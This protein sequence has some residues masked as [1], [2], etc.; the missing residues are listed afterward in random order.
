MTYIKSLE[1]HG[2]KSFA[3][4]T[5]LVFPKG[6]NIIVGS[7]GSGKCLKGDSKVLLA[8]GEFKTIKSL[9][10]NALNKSKHVS[11]LDDGVLTLENP[12]NIKVLCLN[13]NT[14][15]ISEKRVS[16]FVKRA[17][18][19][20]LVKIKTRS[21]RCVVAT[22]HHPVFV[23]KNKKIVSLNAGEIKTGDYIAM[24]KKYDIQTSQKIDLLKISPDD[25]LYVAWSQEYKD[26]IIKARKK[27][28][29]TA[30]GIPKNFIKGAI[31]GQSLNLGWL[32]KIFALIGEKNKIKNV[33]E[34]RAMHGNSIK[35]PK[36]LSL[37]LAR[38][39]AYLIAEG[40]IRN[41]TLR[42]VNNCK[43][44]ID[45]FCY[46]ANKVFG[47]S[48]TVKN[49]KGY[50]YDALIFNRALCT[51]LEKVLGLKIHSKA[52]TKIIPFCILKAPKKIIASFLGA[53]Y[54]C[55]GWIAKDR[56]CLEYST[57]SKEIADGILY[58]MQR[59]GIYARIKSKDIS[60]KHYYY[61]RIYGAESI[62]KLRS[63]GLRFLRKD[64]ENRLLRICNLK[65]NSWTSYD[66]LPREINAVVRSLAK[67][68]GINVKNFSKKYPRLSAYYNNDCQPTRKGIFLLIPIFEQQY[69]YVLRKALNLCL[70]QECLIQTIDALPMSRQHASSAIG[71]NKYTITNSWVHG[72]FNAK[73]KNLLKLYTYLKEELDD[74]LGKASADLKLLKA[75]VNS[76]IYW[77]QIVS[78]QEVNA[79]EWVYDLSI[80]KHHNFISEGFFVHN[81]NVIDAL[82]FVLGK[83]SKKSMRAEKLNDLIFNGG[84]KGKPAKSCSVTI[85]F[86]NSNKEF[87]YEGD[88][89]SITRIV[90]RDGKS[91][92]KINDAIVK[93]QEILN[94]LAFANLNPDGYN[95]ILQG[96]IQKFV[97][98]S[99]E[100]R[101]SIIEEISGISIYENKKHKAML[102][103]GKVEEKL[104][105]ARAVLSERE[106]FL[107]ELIN[108][109]K[110][111]EQYLK[112]KQELKELKA[113]LLFK[114]I[115]LQET[116]KQELEEKLN[117]SNKAISEYE[118]RI[119][120]LKALML[121]K[122]DE[123]ARIKS[124]IEKRGQEEQ[125]RLSRE[126]EALKEK[127]L[128][129]QNK[130]ESHEAELKRIKERKTSVKN[131]LSDINERINKQEMRLG[132]DYLK[133]K[134][135][136]QA[137]EDELLEKKDKLLLLKQ[138][139]E[140]MKEYNKLLDK[141][142]RAEGN[143]KQIVEKISK[144]AGEHSAIKSKTA[145][146]EE[147][148]DNLNAR[149]LK[150]EAKRQAGIN[151]LKRGV[152]EVLKIK[153][154]V[155][156]IHGTL[157]ELG[158]VDK[159]YATALSVCAGNK[160]FSIVT[161]TDV[162]AEQCINYL[163][164]N[165]LGIA[166]FMPLNKIRG[167]KISESL[168]ELKR[169]SG[170]IDFA[171]NL[172][173]FD[174]KYRPA[175]ELALGNTLVVHD[176]E[177]A[178][179]V[180]I[181]IVRMVTLSGDLIESSGVITGGYRNPNTA[182]FIEQGIEDNLK[183][184][185]AK[186][187]KYERYLKELEAK[188]A[189]LN[190]E[191]MS[192][193]ENRARQESI[194]EEL[195]NTIQELGPKVKPSVDYDLL[196]N[197]IKTLE[198][199][200]DELKSKTEHKLDEKQLL[201]IKESIDK[202][203][204]QVSDLLVEKRTIES[205]LN[206]LLLKEAS[207]LKSILADLDKEKKEFSQEL[208]DLK[209][210]L[211]QTLSEL[212]QKEIEE[213]KFYGKLK[214]FYTERDKIERLISKLE[215]DESAFKDKIY[216]LKEKTQEDRIKLASVVAKLEGLH[217]AF[218]E[219]K[220]VQVKLLKRPV[221]EI[222]ASIRKLEVKIESFGNVNLKALEA[223]KEAKADYDKIK[224]KS[225]KLNY[226]KQE[227]LNVIETIE[228]RKKDAFLKTF[229]EVSKNFAEIFSA[230]SPGGIAKM[231]LDN[232]E[233]PFEGGV[234]IMA[235]PKGKKILNLAS[236]SG[237]EKTITALAFIFSIQEYEPAPF[238][239]MDEVDAALDKY[240]SEVLAEL[241]RNY[242][243][244]AQF[245]VIS[246]ND[247]MISSADYLYGVSMNPD[248]LSKVVTLKLP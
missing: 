206:N 177:A 222:D 111:A 84:K 208:V 76:D 68:L 117:A 78:I 226:E 232:P 192:L 134:K 233:N 48:C 61:I 135:E 55:D 82:C 47:V 89:F 40:T 71:L 25:K 102:E 116:K 138:A 144:L 165:Q 231:Y 133:S 200:R 168:K 74:L 163:R 148:L 241:L 101:R 171:I 33:K 174:E 170:V 224:E 157:S 128:M 207:K 244:N 52:S 219:F 16:A 202:L 199:K 103:L 229:N 201:G 85:V 150:L 166:S 179:N 54:D 172:V 218:K 56:S 53:L 67:K 98:L 80:E 239:I 99:P 123:L 196:L 143:L 43:E 246:H 83:I 73:H 91:I 186:K 221:Q 57:A 181:G 79:E 96:D 19:K 152:R 88:E 234:E 49:Y 159:R 156:G 109:K 35:I 8:N 30:L 189:E 45:D 72:K 154:R 34:I 173:N 7:N 62:K 69:K 81:S 23:F 32:V 193:R 220:D 223:Y 60:N 64:K 228:S 137:I 236:M 86:D 44:I 243:K 125:N 209:S 95:I 194:I 37:E 210:S 115:H 190:E 139:R 39:L 66:V 124:E 11:K 129:I 247:D 146:V 245:I 15:K 65:T 120:D 188:A 230:L 204:T 183:E 12:E 215:K 14:L 90:R 5:R 2:F 59:F 175:F 235:R 227:I 46:C 42:I 118:K 63:Y 136:L 164:R 92:Y 1:L 160:L 70:N 151:Y 13:T 203:N 225:D 176:M 108:E 242:S 155:P 97:S 161:D 113:N 238:Y 237:G 149:I 110:Q 216:K 58:L 107:K 31:D 132:D 41:G 182:S 162:V 10:E 211:K 212:K 24:P 21:G 147:F 119:E 126:I 114:K 213:S 122:K 217:T 187:Q 26:L 191:I 105:E 214:K 180:G 140:K 29:L 28:N 131:E 197:E 27:Y 240:N 158:V 195:S 51:F 127:K 100:Q 205:E 184:L 17:S 142:A 145:E 93:R 77:E 169:K 9:V 104:R 6:L 22:K 112:L 36:K 178:R 38:F 167:I 87:P 153:D 4:K 3:H 141:K 106:R 18:P 75:L 130:I 198:T 20:C 94:A 121:E 185:G 50:A 248:G